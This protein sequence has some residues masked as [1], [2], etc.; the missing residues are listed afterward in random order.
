VHKFKVIEQRLKARQANANQPQPLAGPLNVID[1]TLSVAR[2]FARACCY[3]QMR[4]F[5]LFGPAGVGKSFAVESEIDSYNVLDALKFTT[6]RSHPN[7][8]WRRVM[9]D[10]KGNLVFRPRARLVSG[11]ISD[12]M[13]YMLL[14]EHSEPGEFICFDDSDGAWSNDTVLNLLK[15]A[16]DTK[17]NR[18]VT[19]E[20]SRQREKNLPTWF[21]MEGSVAI[22]SNKQRRLVTGN[23]AAHIE[24]LEDRLPPLDLPMYTVEQ[25]LAWIERLAPT[26]LGKP[27]ALPTGWRDAL[28]PQEQAMLLRFIHEHAEHFAQPI[29]LRTLDHCAD[30]LWI[31]RQPDPKRPP[32]LD[33]RA[34]IRASMFKRA[35]KWARE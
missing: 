15:A 1:E 28:T 26:M 25:R 5:L 14:F 23:I 35:D 17:R 6:D 21:R 31:G 29:S 4:G 34:V 11:G 27:K 24:A 22:I 13:V 8:N 12:Y 20:S 2:Q 32:H 19:W 33:W 3:G 18:I 9:T 7:F 10:P 16:T 30:Q